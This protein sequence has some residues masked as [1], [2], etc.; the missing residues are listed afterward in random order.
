MA[1]FAWTIALGKIL[2]LDNLR[3][4]QIV[5]INR[6]CLCMSD[7]ESVDHLL[8]HCEVAHVLWHAIFSRFRLHWVMPCRVEDLNACWGT[9]GRSRS[10]VVWKMIPLCL[11]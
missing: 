9:G 7:K 6:C 10:A 4:K 1:F 2:T 3:K 5:V 8:L 11:M